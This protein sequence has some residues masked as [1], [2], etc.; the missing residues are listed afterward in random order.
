MLTI[1][2]PRDNVKF[3][4]PAFADPELAWKVLSLEESEDYYD[5]RLS[6]LQVGTFWG[7]PGTEQF[8]TDKIGEIWLMQC[9]LHESR[10]FFTETGLEQSILRNRALH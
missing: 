9:G 5:I 10:S 7:R 2:R 4:S 8:T 3:Y 6:Y 1:E